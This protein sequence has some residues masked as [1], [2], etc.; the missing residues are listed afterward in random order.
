MN[1]IINP[2]TCTVFNY[3]NIPA[4]VKI[5]YQEKKLTLSGVVGPM[6][7]GNCRGSCGQII[8]EIRTGKPNKANGWTEEMIVKLCDIWKEW[9]NNDLHPECEHQKALGW[10]DIASKCVNIYHWELNLQTV[11]EKNKL[12]RA[13]ISSLRNGESFTP[14]AEQVKLSRLPYFLKTCTDTLPEDKNNFYKAGKST[15]SGGHVE[16][17]KL[18]HILPDEHPDGILT[19]PC[20]MC[21]YKYGTAWNTVEVPQE[22]IDWLF[23]LPKSQ[24]TPA[25]I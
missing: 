17:K 13:A 12:E 24:R 1:L 4:F 2:C 3:K 8:D 15:W 14:T 20:P 10:K 5:S 6:S 23:A 22:V 9:H 11:T 7:S 25:W 18:G 19:K 21:G 16:P